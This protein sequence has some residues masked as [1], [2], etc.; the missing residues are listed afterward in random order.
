MDLKPSYIFY[1]QDSINN[2]FDKR[3]SH[4]RTRIGETLDDVCEGRCQLSS[5]PTIT[6]VKRDGKW[7]TADN[8]RLWVFRELERLGK[9]DTIPV[10]ISAYIPEA[11]LTTYNGGTSVR[12]RGP[13]GG[14]WH[15]KP[16]PYKPT[17]QSTL[18]ISNKASA[19]QSG[20]KVKDLSERPALFSYQAPSVYKAPT[21]KPQSSIPTH[22][23]NATKTNVAMT[24]KTSPENSPKLTIRSTSDSFRTNPLSSG[25]QATYKTPVKITPMSYSSSKYPSFSDIGKANDDYSQRHTHSSLSPN[26]DHSSC[27]KQVGSS[28]SHCR[29]QN[30]YSKESG[31][32]VLQDRVPHS[33]YST[34]GASS[35]SQNCDQLSN[36]S[37]QGSPS[38]PTVSM[39][40]SSVDHNSV[41]ATEHASN[42]SE[43]RYVMPT[44]R[45]G[46]RPNYGDSNQSCCG[47]TIL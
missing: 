43:P 8:R 20:Y 29:D 44:Y 11:K 10:R 37:K 6:V 25:L 33:N 21:T 28:G 12:V 9:C 24:A 42:A 46:S 23:T 41:R 35:G 4:N 5:I 3:T 34:E 31:L 45:E 18:Q 27:S 32:S 30:S 16:T 17:V 36:Y 40:D 19:Y 15:N 7:V 38:R 13:A 22:M 47:C 14:Y 2:V 39:S 26:R 1:S